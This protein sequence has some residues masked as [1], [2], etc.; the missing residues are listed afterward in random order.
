MRLLEG[1]N[2][3]ELT[4][5][6]RIHFGGVEEAVELYKEWEKEQRKRSRIEYVTDIK[7]KEF[8]KMKRTGL[9][10]P[11]KQPMWY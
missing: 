8:K 6:D 4:D 9:R 2:N 3:K 10:G 7:K 5:K 1:K 11:P